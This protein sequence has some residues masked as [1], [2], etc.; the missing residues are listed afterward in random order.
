M[1]YAVLIHRHRQ[2]KM[3]TINHDE[4]ENLVHTVVYDQRGRRG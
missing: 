2:K 3:M 4:G 1:C